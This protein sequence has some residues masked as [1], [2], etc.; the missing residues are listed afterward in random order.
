VSCRRGDW[1][2]SGDG[3]R[4]RYSEC[5]FDYAKDVMERSSHARLG[6]QKHR[7]EWATNWIYSYKAF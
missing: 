2:K 5:D 4:A 6:L 1:W 3:E 7:L